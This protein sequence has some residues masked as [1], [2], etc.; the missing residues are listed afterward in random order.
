[1]RGHKTLAR[2]F[3]HAMFDGVN[4]GGQKVGAEFTQRGL[5]D[6]ADAPFKQ[7]LTGFR[8][9]FIDQTDDVFLPVFL[10]Q[11]LDHPSM[12]PPTQ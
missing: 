3:R 4:H 12:P 5:E 8:R 6:A 2:R 11:G 9:E 7:R 1:M 10:L